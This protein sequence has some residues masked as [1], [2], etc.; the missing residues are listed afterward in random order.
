MKQYYI[1]LSGC[2][3]IEIN[4]PTDIDS[5]EYKNQLIELIQ[6]KGYKTGEILTSF[7]FVCPDKLIGELLGKI[8]VMKNKIAF[9]IDLT[10]NH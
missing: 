10:V 3:V 2:P 8:Q 5:K 6:G 1:S 9:Q 4:K 7:N